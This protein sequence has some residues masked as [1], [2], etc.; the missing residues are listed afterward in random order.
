MFSSE[1]QVPELVYQET[2]YLNLIKERICQSKEQGSRYLFSIGS[3]ER[4]VTVQTL[5]LPF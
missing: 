4:G 5:S 1:K 3:F 2:D